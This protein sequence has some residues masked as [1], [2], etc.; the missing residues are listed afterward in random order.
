MR[1]SLLP[2]RACGLA[3][4]CSAV[5][6]ALSLCALAPSAFAE[7]VSYQQVTPVGAYDAVPRYET[8]TGPPLSNADYVTPDG[9]SVFF[10]TIGPFPGLPSTGGRLDVL[11][12]SRAAD[13]TWSTTWMSPGADTISGTNT[14]ERIFQAAS[15]DGTKVIFESRDQLDPSRTDCGDFTEITGETLCYLR[16][17]EY[18]ASSGRT[19]LISRAQVQPEALFDARFA[20]ASADLG[21]VEWLTPE[22]MTPGVEDQNSIDVYSAREGAGALVSAPSGSTG[23]VSDKRLVQVTGGLSANGAAIVEEFAQPGPLETAKVPI[24]DYQLPAR[25]AHLVSADGSEVFFQDVRQLTAA[26]PGP[27]I[28]NVYMRRGITTTL[29][30]SPAQRTLPPTVAPSASFFADATPDGASVF[31]E[32]SSQLTD[33][34]GN[35]SVD[36]YRY[37]IPTGQVSL[38]SA[39]GH[40]QSAVVEAT[41]SYY[42]TASADGSHVYLASRDDLDPESAPPGSAWKLY[43]RVAGRTRFIALDP[44]LEDLEG[45]TGA[46][47]SLCAGSNS[48]FGIQEGLG[49]VSAGGCDQVATMRATADGSRLLFESAQPLTPG[50]ASGLR[51]VTDNEIPKS[52]GH[53]INVSEHGFGT[54][55]APEYGCNIYV[56]DDATG[57]I[58]LLSPGATTY[59]AFLTRFGIPALNNQDEETAPLGQPLLMSGDGSRVFFSSKDALVP[60]AVTGLAN[61]YAWSAGAL[62]L[63]SPPDESSDAVYDGNSAD[64]SQVFFHSRQSLIPGADNHGQVAIYDAQLGAPPPAG[65]S[66]PPSAPQ[67]VASAPAQTLTVNAAAVSVSAASTTPPLMPAKPRSLTRAQ[68]LSR[69]LRLCLGKHNKKKRAVCQAQA[70]KTYGPTPKSKAKKSNG[71]GRGSR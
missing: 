16:V 63:V 38:V 61:I 45:E 26:A 44:E 70:R 21:T 53:P 71:N 5:F 68:K 56:Y 60:G 14:H 2:L 36:V 47:Q 6:G 13:G 32:T 8:F 58:T 23:S 54:G 3:L 9:A 10:S 55:G 64:G 46:Q 22:A 50:A 27:E 66:D 33:G 18:D 41:G 24:A 25:N 29:L 28:E 37:D 31:F 69:A 15:A 19:S 62:T 39:V 51:C 40:T 67:P 7:Q 11:R 30:S 42:V 52:Q 4:A 43:E 17:Y 1:M 20:S 65:P 34:D 59:G 57:A 48:A 12:A 35:A 49:N